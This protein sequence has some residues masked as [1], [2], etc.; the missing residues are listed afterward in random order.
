[1]RELPMSA[2]AAAAVADVVA[3]V[4]APGRRGGSSEVVAC[5]EDAWDREHDG[6]GSSCWDLSFHMRRQK[7]P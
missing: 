3:V 1:M 4:A 2:F 5:F 6:N 7:A